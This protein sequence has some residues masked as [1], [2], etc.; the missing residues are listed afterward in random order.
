MKG[1]YGGTGLMD[2]RNGME[3]RCYRLACIV[4]S[5]LFPL[6]S[7]V[8]RPYCYARACYVDYFIRLLFSYCGRQKLDMPFGSFSMSFLRPR[9]DVMMRFRHEYLIMNLFFGYIYLRTLYFSKQVVSCP[10]GSREY[11]DVCVV[12]S[13]FLP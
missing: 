1:S 5:Y 6:S 11:T 4:P 8:P 7:T 13:V 3:L 9:L 10:I 2:G 12:Y